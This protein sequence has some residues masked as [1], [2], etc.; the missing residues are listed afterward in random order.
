MVKLTDMKILPIGNITNQLVLLKINCNYLVNINLNGS[1]MRTPLRR[2]W[3]ERKEARR[4]FNRDIMT[5]QT[6]SS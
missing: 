1:L 4:K 3:I 5:G 2:V 6:W